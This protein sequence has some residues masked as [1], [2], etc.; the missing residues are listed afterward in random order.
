MTAETPW[1]L[2][3]PLRIGARR[4]TTGEVDGATRDRLLDATEELLARNGVGRTSM[5]DVARVAGVARGTLYRYFDSKEA[6][7]D[8][9]TER[10]AGRFFAA[11]TT[12]MDA[13]PTLS[14]QLGAFSRTMIRSIHDDDGQPTR[15]Q[16]PM[17]RMLVAQ[18]PR[19]LR[20]T[21]REL[22]PYL[23]AAR[24]RGEVRAD[25]DA[26][27]ASEWLARIMLSFTVFQA[28]IAYPA[29]DPESVASFVRRYV[30]DGLAP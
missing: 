28:S 8:G 14:A 18:G 7:L 27:D 12:A 1:P 19:A 11:A 10:T 25:L 13:E 5:A 9:V 29:D 30:I 16:V 6:L 20:R 21:A 26:A 15:N 23:E 24:T 2:A 22:R 3:E 17:I 4:A